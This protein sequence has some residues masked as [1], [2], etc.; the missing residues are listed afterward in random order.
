VRLL[1]HYVAS[2]QPAQI[3]IVLF[4]LLILDL[5]EALFCILIVSSCSGCHSEVPVKVIIVQEVG[6]NGFEIDKHIIK[7]LQDKEARSHALSPWDC[8]ALRW[9]CTNHLEKVL[10]DSEMFFLV[11]VLANYNMNHSFENVFFGD[12][13]LHV[14]YKVVCFINFII[15]QI[16]Y[17]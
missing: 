11:S 7:L 8:V 14:F 6:S 1:V 10:C 17:N 16:V 13:T 3:D 5:E 12:D 4:V 9:G 15:L 2:A